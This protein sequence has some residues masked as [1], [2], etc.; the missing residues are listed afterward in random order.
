MAAQV[1]EACWKRAGS[2][3]EACRKRAGSVLEACWKL[4]EAAGSRRKDLEAVFAL[5]RWPSVATR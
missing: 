2:V 3:L 1:L 5:C 4:P